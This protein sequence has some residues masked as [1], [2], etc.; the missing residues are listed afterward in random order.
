MFQIKDFN[1][2][3]TVT[4]CS[5]SDNNFKTL[6]PKSNKFQEKQQ[7]ILFGFFNLE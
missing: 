4:L 2:K 7:L 3:D 5:D 1:S 6:K